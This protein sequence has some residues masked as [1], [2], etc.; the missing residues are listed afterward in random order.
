VSVH[1]IIHVNIRVPR[2]RLAIC[3]DFYC[4]VMGLQVGWRPEFVSTGFWLYADGLPIVHLV[5]VEGAERQVTHGAEREVG[6]GHPPLDHVAFRCT[7]YEAMLEKLAA[8]GIP[9]RISTVPGLEIRQVNLTDPVGVGVE[10]SYEAA[11]E[12]PGTNWK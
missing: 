5:G 9:Y 7:G 10:L 6:R 3:R 12:P 4:D 11:T 2:D 8:L 1:G